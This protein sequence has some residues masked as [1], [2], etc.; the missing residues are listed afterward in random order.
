MI[1]LYIFINIYSVRHIGLMHDYRINW[2]LLYSAWHI[3]SF[4]IFRSF[5]NIHF[6]NTI[7]YYSIASQLALTVQDCACTPVSCCAQPDFSRFPAVCHCT[8][9]YFALCVL[10]RS[11]KCDC[12]TPFY[13]FSVFRL[14]FSLYFQIKS[15][16]LIETYCYFTADAVYKYFVYMFVTH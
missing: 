1:R 11:W 15:L 16:K 6:S 3:I 9:D 7:G 8:D 10:A 5:L 13:I 12:F 14:H 2:C 4:F